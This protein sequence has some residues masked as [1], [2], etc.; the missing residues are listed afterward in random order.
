MNVKIKKKCQE[1]RAQKSRQCKGK[2]S[3]R[4]RGGAGFQKEARGGLVGSDTCRPRHLHMQHSAAN[5]GMRKSCSNSAG[6]K[7]THT[8]THTAAT[9][10]S[11][12]THTHR[13]TAYA[14]VGKK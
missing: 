8:H 6:K 10:I 5:T 1:T 7:S 14:R 9:H 4:G 13:H 3:K 12:K 2:V 11:P